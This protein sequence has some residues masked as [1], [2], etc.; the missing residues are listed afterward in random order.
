VG[1]TLEEWSVAGRAVAI[2]TLVQARH[3]APLPPGARLAVNDEGEL[4]GSI[5]NG[6]VEGDLYEHLRAILSGAPAAVLHYGIT[7]DMAPDV[8]LTCGG[9]I[10]VLVERH[11]ASDPA[12][13]QLLRAVEKDE[14]AVLV[15]G[16]SE[17][18][19]SRKLVVLEERSA[20]SLGARPL[21]DLAA[22]AARPY[23][24]SGGTD[25]VSLE[26]D[27]G[28]VADV[29][30]EAHLPPWRLAIVGATSIGYALC[31]FATRLGY[32]VDVIDPRSVLADPA[33]LPDAHRVLHAWPDD[34]LAEIGLGP[35]VD[36]VVLTHDGKLDVPALAAALRA[37]CRYVGLLGGKRTQAHRRQALRELG[38]AE[39]D[40]ERLHGPV[41]LAIGSVTPEEIAL[42][43]AA[44]LVETRRRA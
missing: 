38:F 29:F 31:Q 26:M 37:R 33:K 44:E 17:I 6:C 14:P 42:S 35:P 12:W 13:R 11:D 8:G 28:R 10:N 2:A 32:Q 3:S 15:T 22:E 30:I 23:L 18:I 9:E 16:L 43:I 4:E 19:R 25:V 5:S 24:T 39:S 41:G 21:D 34:G 7:D 27:S 40:L 36:V 1:R 20:G